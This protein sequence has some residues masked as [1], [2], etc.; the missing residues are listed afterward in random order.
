MIVRYGDY[1]DFKIVFI[2][3]NLSIF[4]KYKNYLSII[5]NMT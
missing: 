4:I 5:P 2:Y 3:I 1:G